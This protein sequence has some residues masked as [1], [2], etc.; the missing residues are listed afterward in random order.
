MCV[1]C[2]VNMCCHHCRHVLSSCIATIFVTKCYYHVLILCVL[3]MCFPMFCQ[4]L[5][6]VVTF[7]HVLSPC[8]VLILC[9]TKLSPCVVTMCCRHFFVTLLSLCFVTICRNHV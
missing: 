6:F 2:V 3:E 8:V 5:A 7:W 9:H 4:L 1:L